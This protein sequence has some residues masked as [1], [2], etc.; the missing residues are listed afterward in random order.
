MPVLVCLI[1]CLSSFAFSP[2]SNPAVGDRTWRAGVSGH[3]STL[4]GNWLFDAC[5]RLPRRLPRSFASEIGYS[6]PVLVCHS[7]PGLRLSS[8]AAL[9]CG[10]FVLVSRT[11]VTLVRGLR[12]ERS[13]E[14]GP[15]EVAVLGN[16]QHRPI[17]LGIAV[18]VHRIEARQLDL[19]AHH[20]QLVA[21]GALASLIAPG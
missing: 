15:A 4:G 7:C 16:I 9:V 21:A 11:I 19:F 3:Q 17:F 5:P 1:R 14:P 12:F 2:T 13:I 10:S 8:F 6:I 20:G 18:G